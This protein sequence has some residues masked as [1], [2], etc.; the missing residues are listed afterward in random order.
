MILLLLLFFLAV[1]GKGID[2]YKLNKHL[3]RQPGRP[4]NLSTPSVFINKMKAIVFVYTLHK[5]VLRIKG[6]KK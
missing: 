1:Q 5:V 6:D 3:K 2:S 4:L